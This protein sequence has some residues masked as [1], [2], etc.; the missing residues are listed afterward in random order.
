MAILLGDFGNKVVKV[1]QLKEIS[2]Q[3]AGDVY[4]LAKWIVAND[5]VYSEQHP[6]ST[7]RTTINGLAT[8]LAYMTDINYEEVKSKFVEAGF[9]LEA[10]LEEDG[11]KTLFELLQ[12]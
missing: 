11:N 10:L 7:R 3:F 1:S 8:K 4:V 2:I 5:L 6:Y 9:S 12:S